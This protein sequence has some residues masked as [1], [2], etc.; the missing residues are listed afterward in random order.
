MPRPNH[1][2][3]LGDPGSWVVV[4]VMDPNGVYFGMLQADDSTG[5][6]LPYSVTRFAPLT[7]Q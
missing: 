4:M 6:R 3:A 2:R 7:P 1:G 5:A